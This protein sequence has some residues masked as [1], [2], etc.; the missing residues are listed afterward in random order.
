MGKLIP[1]FYEKKVEKPTKK[2]PF[3]LTFAKAP[4][5]SHTAVA[6]IGTESPPSASSEL[7]VEIHPKDAKKMHIH[8]QSK[9]KI[10]TK[11]GHVK[12][13]ACITERVLPGVVFIPFLPASGDAKTLRTID[14]R[15][16]IPELHAATCQIKGSGGKQSDQ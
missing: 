8:D 13:N 7:F 15:A 1:V 11:A 14:P 5:F 4:T 9:V 12:A 10:S 6:S 2:F 3:R 16:K